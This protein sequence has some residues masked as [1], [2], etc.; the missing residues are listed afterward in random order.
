M[1]ARWWMALW[2]VLLVG[3]GTPA[4]SVRLE[5]RRGETFLHTP[6]SVGGRVELKPEE[7]RVAVR[8][9]GRDAPVSKNPRT[10][11]LRLFADS[12]P[13]SSPYIRT[14]LG[15]VAGSASSRRGLLLLVDE[16]ASGSELARAYTRWCERK[17]SPRD[18]LGLLE[19]EF[20]LDEQA[21]RTWAFHIALGAVWDETAEALGELTSKEALI[22]LVAA[23]GAVYFSLWLLPEPV[24]KGI[25][26][27]LTVGL[28]AYLGWDTV[29]SLIQGFG[30][31]SARV[32]EATTFEE[33]RTAGEEYG[34]IMG[35]NAA[36]V[37][38]LLATAAIGS[39][40][41]TMAERIPPLPGSSRAA[42]VGLGQMGVRLSAV[43]LVDA[44][45]VSPEGALSIALAPGA[46]AATVQGGAELS[47]TEGHEHHL[48]TN[49]WKDASHSG[50]P[51]TPKFE[52]LF[53]RAGMSLDDPANKVR[54]N[55]HKGP[56]PQKYHEEVYERLRD[57]IEDCVSMR[58]CAE[59]LTSALR[60][61]AEEASTP[62]TRLNKWVTK[63]E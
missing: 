58:Q 20:M 51:W 1:R 30:A 27:V 49:K 63:S 36:R 33:V 24:S 44:V 53:E 35:R 25:A 16:P 34:Q 32:R 29:W 62:G 10:F 5:T 37:F 14:S 38:I 11:A 19:G 60:A 41:Q 59:R 45:V 6:R 43:G 18:C 48:A 50:G 8:Q 21:R 57:A 3:C 55:G 26:A 12:V 46:V 9:L 2:L 40:A 39:T 22:D 42:V 31:L 15:V 17:N 61:L 7:F 13:S 23:T 28:I 47:D 54:I 52:E 56:H 4:K